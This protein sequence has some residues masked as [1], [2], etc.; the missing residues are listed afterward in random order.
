MSV[1]TA[2][3]LNFRGR[4]RD[5]LEFYRS[6][7]GGHLLAVTY[8][9]GHAVQRPD[10]AD[11]VMWG[12]VRSDDG[13]LVMAYDVPAS[14]DH[15]AGVDPVFVSVRGQDEDEIR[16]YWDGLCEGA[17]VKAPLAPAGWALLYGM[18]TDRFGVTWVLDVPAPN[19]T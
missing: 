14:R 2:V 10:E 17:T 6:V 11:Q 7:F 12:E 16:R 5:A 13:F 19:P 15:D 8:A 4:A 3:H 1:T 9:D 18:L